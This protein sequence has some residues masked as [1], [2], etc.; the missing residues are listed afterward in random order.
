MKCRAY[1]KNKFPINLYKGVTDEPDIVE[2]WPAPLRL[3][4]E[5]L[6]HIKS[7]EVC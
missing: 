6:E 4:Y 1:E 2:K 7:F 3:I 5:S